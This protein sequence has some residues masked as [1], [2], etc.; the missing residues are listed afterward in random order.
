MADVNAEAKSMPGTLA[1]EQAIHQRLVDHLH[2]GREYYRPPPEV[3]AEV[4]ALRAGLGLE[5]R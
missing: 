3:M 2:H 5:A 1:D 4:N